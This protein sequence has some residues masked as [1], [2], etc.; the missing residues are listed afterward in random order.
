MTARTAEEV[1]IPTSLTR[2]AGE[3][4]CSQTD[5]RRHSQMKLHRI[6]PLAVLA[7]AAC[8]GSASTDEFRASAPTFD[9]RAISQNDSDTTDAPAPAAALRATATTPDCHPH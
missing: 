6:L 2:P 3:G 9:N 8:G 4:S 1:F 7:A 5:P